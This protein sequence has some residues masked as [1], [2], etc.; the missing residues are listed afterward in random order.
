MPFGY[1]WDNLGNAAVLSRTRLNHLI[2]LQGSIQ[3][4]LAAAPLELAYLYKQT[5][6]HYKAQAEVIALVGV[7][8]I[9]I[10]ATISWLSGA[11]LGPALLSKVCAFP[12]EWLHASTGC[13]S[14]SRDQHLRYTT[15]VDQNLQHPRKHRSRLL[16]GH[17]CIDT[18]SWEVLE[19]L[20]CRDQPL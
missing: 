20:L 3:A 8:S 7:F 1:V 13:K 18:S 17:N 14:C 15:K 10:G 11:V 9:L 4:T 12:A 2:L 6:Q 19:E 5:T 16:L